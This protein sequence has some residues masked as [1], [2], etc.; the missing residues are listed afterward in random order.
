MLG[1]SLVSQLVQNP[2]GR[3]G[4]D[5]WVRKIPW[6]SERLPTPVF[7]PGEFQGL[8][9]PRGRKESDMTQILSLIYGLKGQKRQK[10]EGKK[11]VN[12]EINR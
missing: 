7:W 12:A 11:K 9:S 4:F 3:P 5:P 8:Y 6:R 2:L 10:L 1:S